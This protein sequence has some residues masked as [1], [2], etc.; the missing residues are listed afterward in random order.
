MYELLY[1]W[2]KSVATLDQFKMA[3]NASEDDMRVGVMAG[4]DSGSGNNVA[5]A[6]GEERADGRRRRRAERRE[7]KR[8]KR[9]AAADT[10]RDG[11]G[12]DGE[13]DCQ[14]GGGSGSG[15]DRDNDG[16]DSD[17]DGHRTDDG[18]CGC[19]D[20]SAG[21]D[22]VDGGS[23]SSSA[24]V[25]PGN[26]PKGTKAA[27]KKRNKKKRSSRGEDSSASAS[28]RKHRQGQRP[29]R[30]VSDERGPRRCFDG[31]HVAVLGLVRH[32]C[33]SL[34]ECECSYVARHSAKVL[35]ARLMESLSR[36]LTSC[37]S[38]DRLVPRD[39]VRECVTTR[40]G[41]FERCCGECAQQCVPCREWYPPSCSALHHDC[42]LGTPCL[43]ADV[44]TPCSL[45]PALVRTQT[46]CFTPPPMT[47]P[48]SPSL[49]PLLPAAQT[50]GV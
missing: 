39:S 2:H 24:G 10:D 22:H 12:S 28:K 23:S 1:S 33:A 19:D 13:F 47:L 15:T 32:G 8:Q 4:D 29:R 3:S 50:T 30:R 18:D 40:L 20:D 44:G 36:E 49:R 9:L 38:C 27:E 21:A 43:A 34:S 5:A 48:D 17:G 11:C 16:G 46:W 42:G 31:A 7:A 37:A 25:G 26:S 6:D 14:C 45:P 35:G 41:V